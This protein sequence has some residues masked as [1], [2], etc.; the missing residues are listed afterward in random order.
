[1]IIG[2][3]LLKRNQSFIESY[4]EYCGRYTYG[5]D[6]DVVT[7][8]KNCRSDNQCIWNDYTGQNGVQRGWC[9]VNP[10]PRYKSHDYSS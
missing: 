3:F 6:Y 4:G 2:L 7:C 5:A 1:M 9:G 10:N 8:K